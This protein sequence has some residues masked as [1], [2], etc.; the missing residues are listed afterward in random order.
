MPVS[1]Q[2]EVLTAS[3]L[4]E[5]ELKQELAVA[6]FERERITLA[7]ASRL[8]GLTQLEFQS[9]LAQREVPVHYGVQEFEE[10]LDALRRLR[11]F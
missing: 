10:D 7:Q 3:G 1:I 4:S 11:Q 9:V 6:L 5:G 8:A 2:D